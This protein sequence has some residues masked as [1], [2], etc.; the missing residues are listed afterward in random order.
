MPTSTKDNS[1]NSEIDKIEPIEKVA[2][3][4]DDGTQVISVKLSKDTKKKKRKTTSVKEKETPKEELDRPEDSH[5]EPAESVPSEESPDLTTKQVSS[6]SQL[7]SESFPEKEASETS[8]EDEKAKDPEETGPKEFLES[9]NT[10]DKSQEDLTENVK[11]WLEDIHPQAGPDDSGKSGFNFKGLFMIFGILLILG[12]VIGGFYFYQSSQEI[13]TETPTPPTEQE[14]EITPTPTP[15]VEE[16]VDLSSY[17]LQVLNGTGIAGE[18]GRVAATLEA[19]GFVDVE[20]GNASSSNVE[21]TQ[22]QMKEEVPSEVFDTIDEALSTRD[23]VIA[24]EVLDEDSDFDV[25]I[26]LGS[27]DREEEA[28]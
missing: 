17:S 16:E 8:E 5:E 9:S 13:T 25:V 23:V 1:E 14:P 6:F 12:L 15:I 3:D 7:D 4:A 2:E 19:G 11:K 28:D 20:A 22:V 18:A 21:Q 10:S 26:T 27:A 24:D